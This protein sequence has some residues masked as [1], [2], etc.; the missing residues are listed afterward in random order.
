MGGFHLLDGDKIAILIASC[1]CKLLGEAGL[2][3]PHEGSPHEGPVVASAESQ[4][5]HSVASNSGQ[6]DVAS[7]AQVRIGI[8]QTAYANGSA[9]RY[10]RQAY[11]SVT[12]ACVPTGTFH[13]HQSGKYAQKVGSTAP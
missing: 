9:T 13:L 5:G 12:V 8:V 11:P 2:L 1:L 7:A 6:M 3:A 4:S 10:L